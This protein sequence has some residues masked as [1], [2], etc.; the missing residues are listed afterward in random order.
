MTSCLSITV[1]RVIDTNK[2]TM[3]LETCGALELPLGELPSGVFVV[4]KDGNQAVVIPVRESSFHENGVTPA[5][6]LESISVSNRQTV[7]WIDD[8]L[9]EEDKTLESP[10]LF[11]TE[12][13]RD[14]D[15]EQRCVTA[16]ENRAEDGCATPVWRPIAYPSHRLMT[17]ARTTVCG[18]AVY[19]SP[20]E[21][22]AIQ[23]VLDAVGAKGL[24]FIKTL[25]AY[26]L[27]PSQFADLSPVL[28]TTQ[29]S[30][31]FGVLYRPT[32][33]D[34]TCLQ[35]VHRWLG[36]GPS[37]AVSGGAFLF[38]HGSVIRRP[39]PCGA[40]GLKVSVYTPNSDVAVD[41]DDLATD[42]TFTK[43]NHIVLCRQSDAY[44][45][46]G[47]QICAPITGFPP[48]MHLLGRVSKRSVGACALLFDT[49]DPASASTAEFDEL[50]HS[51][52]DDGSGTQ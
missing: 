8:V 47:G 19:S 3:R 24:P 51:F 42:W 2:I 25:Q 37:R 31:R 20:M 7:V 50:L 21:A 5:T 41:M 45:R 40:G 28:A 17:R 4:C 44:G 38:L 11:D 9:S 32:P 16:E 23:L 36:S 39:C 33:P 52:T 46:G 34:L 6:I 30:G 26:E 22:Y 43:G 12:E 13:G 10:P 1:S 15:T 14:I 18:D 29:P 48:D 35:S 49:T 27:Q